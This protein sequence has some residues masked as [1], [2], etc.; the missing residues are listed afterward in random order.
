MG[1]GDTDDFELVWWRDVEGNAPCYD[2]IKNDLSPTKRRAL[3][4]ALRHVLQAHGINV[5]GQKS[6]GRQLG[7]GLFEFRLDRTDPD[8]RQKFVLRVFCHAYG[9]R[10]ILA[11]HGYD[12]GE[13]PRPRRQQKEI[14]EARRRLALWEA[15]QRTRRGAA[16]GRGGGSQGRRK[17]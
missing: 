14:A 17:R 16:S 9:D 12:K 11:L 15:D 6:W 13:D 2:W 4:A 8:T 10:K 1:G 5:V 7:E 3:G